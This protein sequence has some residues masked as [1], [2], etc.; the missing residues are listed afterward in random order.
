MVE[1]LVAA[2]S[3]FGYL[4][5]TFA[6]QVSAYLKILK[7]Y[8]EIKGPADDNLYKVHTSL[9]KLIK[10]YND[11]F[12][13][14]LY[15]ETLVAPVMPCGFGLV[16]IREV[17]RTGIIQLEAIQKIVSATLPPFIVCA[18]G[19]IIITQV[20]E[21]HEASYMSRWY[22]E[23]PR[24]RKNLLIMMIRTIKPTTINYR[25]FVTL[26]HRC[27]ASVMYYLLN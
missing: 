23:T 21:L 10:D 6:F 24:I 13:G 7:K 15:Y 20:E 25:L 12:S 2:N 17:R 16:A 8:F 26:D 4:Q 9:L 11:I 14:Q 27:L 5:F 22:E 1:S 18:C 3:T 19:Q